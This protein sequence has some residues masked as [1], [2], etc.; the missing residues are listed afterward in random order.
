MSYT[1]RSGMQV[2]F[3]KHNTIFGIFELKLCKGTSLPFNAIA[4]HQEEAL[5]AISGEEGLYHKISDSVVNMG[6]K[7]TRFTKKKPFDCFR[8]KKQPAYVVIMF[9]KPRIKKNV[10]YIPIRSFIKMR[11]FIDRKSITERMAFEYSNHA[12]SMLA[13]GTVIKDMTQFLTLK[14]WREL[15]KP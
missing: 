14:E 7:E 11:D 13:K 9:Y 2:D 12:V 10:Y 1:E 8:V 6:S 4:D 15:V 5:L 3:K